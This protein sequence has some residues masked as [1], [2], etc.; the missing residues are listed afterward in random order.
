M[1]DGF[2]AR[3]SRRKRDEARRPAEIA[4]EAAPSAAPGEALPRA[5]AP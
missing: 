1:S 5:R 2:L 3:W 4:P